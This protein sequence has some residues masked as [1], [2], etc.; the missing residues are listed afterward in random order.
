MTRI[1]SFGLYQCPICQQ[2]H[3]K[4][5][6]GSIN[7]S[8]SIP[9]DVLDLTDSDIK[10]CKKC[11]CE[12]AIKDYLFLGVRKRIGSQKPNFLRNIAIKVGIAKPIEERDV[13]KLYPCFDY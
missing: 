5:N 4:P 3:I 13:R 11:G 2:T 9:V 7:F 12:N 8:L 10:T 1:V 6:Y